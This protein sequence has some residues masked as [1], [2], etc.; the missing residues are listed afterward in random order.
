M[1]QKF[2]TMDEYIGSF[3]SDVQKI[4][5]TIKTT[6]RKALPTAKE[7]ISYNIPTFKEKKNIIHF[8]AFT[9]HI[10]V[11]PIL[12][13]GTPEM[14]EELAPYVHGKGTL[15]FPLNKPIPYE[16]IGRV[17]KMRAMEVE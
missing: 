16:L 4:L 5:E 7:A 3:P 13:K 11:Y 12:Q 8:A 17:A 6:I 14:M 9:H 2:S 15:Q 1:R 10:G